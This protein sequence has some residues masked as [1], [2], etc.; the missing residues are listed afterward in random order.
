LFNIATAGLNVA[1]LLVVCMLLQNDDHATVLLPRPNHLRELLLDSV[2]TFL[3]ERVGAQ[4][5]RD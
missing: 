5:G 4:E 1:G 2:H 3:S